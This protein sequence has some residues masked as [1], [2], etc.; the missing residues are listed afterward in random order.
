M[1]RVA[2]A[3]PFGLE[4]TL[5]FVRAAA[6]LPGVK[7]GVVS[8]ESPRSLVAKLPEGERASV[9]ACVQVRDAHDPSQL[10][11]AV[12][13][14]S[15]ELGGRVERV[16][17]ILESLQVPLAEVRE[18]L[19]IRGMDVSEARHFR[20][21]AQMKD[22]LRAAHL[23]CARHLLATSPEAAL[24]FGAS[25]M[26]LVAKP[27][28]GAGARDTFRIDRLAALESYVRATPPTR[29]R[30]LLLE[31]F[32]TGVE[33]SFDAVTLGGRTVFHSISIYSPTPLHVMATPWIQWTVLLPR[34]IDGPEYAAIR[35][36]GPRAIELLGMV[37]G[38]SHMEWFRRPDGSIAISEVGARPPGAQFTSLLSYAH[39]HDFYRAWA[40]VVIFERFAAPERKY[41]AGAAYLRGQ[42]HGQVIAVEG[43]ESVRRELGDM[44]VEAK[45]PRPGQ[46]KASSYEG[47]G[48]VILRH[49]ETE[50]VRAGLERLVST[51]R[52]HLGPSTIGEGR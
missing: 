36:A 26:P 44:V 43:I 4:S 9:L 13:S 16:I 19:G 39:D 18:R 14:L 40:E 47:E 29:E 42:G 23:P 30:P 1:T 7:L 25:T 33:H 37:N 34:R 49:P 50:A 12:E 6:A 52:V 46:P 22:A 5:R 17:G 10:A 20:D 45:I 31:E 27:P 24:E 35:A 3:A 38:M 48:Y 8:Q 51:L 11:E 41:A 21:K 15:R 28:S 2:F 32:V